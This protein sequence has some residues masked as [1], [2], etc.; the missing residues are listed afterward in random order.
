MKDY[1]LVGNKIDRESARV[2]TCADALALSEQYCSPY[3]ECS[4]KKN[5]NISQ[6]FEKAGDIFLRDLAHER[7]NIHPSPI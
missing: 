5:I 1:I 3:I 4:A 7:K 6:I 2:I